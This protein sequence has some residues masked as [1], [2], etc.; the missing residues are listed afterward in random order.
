MQR[1]PY[2]DLISALVRRFQKALDALSEQPQHR[3]ENDGDR[4]TVVLVWRF[5]PFL[6]QS[7][8]AGKL[9]DFDA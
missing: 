4:H 9:V 1:E 7:T 8:F 2:F 5:A 6:P 3:P